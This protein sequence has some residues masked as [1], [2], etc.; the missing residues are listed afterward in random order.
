MK[1]AICIPSVLSLILSVAACSAE[2]REKPNIVLLLADDQRWDS[3]GAYGN[4]HVTHTPNLDRLAAAGTLFE[5]GFVTTSVCGPSRTSILTGKYRRART[6][7]DRL[8]E[9]MTPKNWNETYP[10]LMKE[11]GYWTGY[12]GKWDVAGEKGFVQGASMFNFWAGD[13]Y[14]G[15]YWHEA[16]CVLVTANGLIGKADAYCDCPPDNNSLPRIG[17]TGMDGPI[18]H[19][20]EELA[21][22]KFRQ[23]LDSRDTTRP[24]LFVCSFRSPKNAVSVSFPQKPYAGYYHGHIS[25]SPVA[26][27]KAAEAAPPY[28]KNSLGFKEGLFDKAS[29]LQDRIR[30]HH[31]CVSAM[32]AGIGAMRAELENRKLA[33]NT[34]IIYLADNGEML[35]D[36]GSFG[37]WIAYEGSIR[38]PYIVYDPRI[39]PGQRRH[40][41]KEMVLNIDVAPTMLDLAKAPI[42]ASMHGRS[43]VK[44]LRNSYAGKWREDFFYEHKWTASNRIYPS[45]GIRTADWKYLRYYD[46]SGNGSLVGEQLF[47]VGTDPFEQDDLIDDPEYA[48]II[49]EMRNRVEFYYVLEE[50][51]QEGGVMPGLPVGETSSE[52]EGK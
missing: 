22:L 31:R 13:R 52:T 27:A 38:V 47:K 35:G 19:T 18:L 6:G 28:I 39:P 15:N 48:S 42:P 34:V 33:E 43:Y 37:K 8:A 7:D 24:F 16:D 2:A 4:P 41:S 36:F 25:G 51:D 11:A 1:R 29:V 50:E 26:N 44:L 46:I 45:E 3:V 5:N 21:P 10:A 17:T 23:F 49:E 9:L 20:D 30:N 14:H 40:I 32:D 12:F